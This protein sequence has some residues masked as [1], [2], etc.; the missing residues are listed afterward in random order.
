MCVQCTQISCAGVYKHVRF[1]KLFDRS[2]K[3]HTCASSLNRAVPYVQ[4]KSLIS[5]E[6]KKSP[7]KDILNYLNEFIAYFHKHDWL[8]HLVQKGGQVTKPIILVKIYYIK[9]KAICL[10][11]CLFDRQYH[12]SADQNRTNE[13]CVFRNHIVYLYKLSSVTIHQHECTKGIGV[14]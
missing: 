4:P 14:S 5:S 6:A 2:Y 10:S 11:V 7:I 12:I 1:S 3:I 9:Q 13:S 8:C